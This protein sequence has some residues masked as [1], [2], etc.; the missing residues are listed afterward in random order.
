MSRQCVDSRKTAASRQR[1]TW[2]THIKAKK[3]QLE[4]KLKTMYWLMNKR[5]KLSVENKLTIYTAILRPVWIN[6]F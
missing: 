4:L 5:S 2:K 3:R 1:L 6:G